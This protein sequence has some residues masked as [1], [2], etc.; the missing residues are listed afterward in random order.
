MPMLGASDSSTAIQDAMAKLREASAGGG[1]A[2]QA[3]A[4][5]PYRIPVKTGASYNLPSNRGKFD[6][7]IHTVGK[8][9]KEKHDVTEYFTLSDEGVSAAIGAWY[10]FDDDERSALMKRMWYLGLI[11]D[12]SDFDAAYKTWQA[13]VGHAARF[14]QTGKEIDPRD[15]L[16]I[17]GDAKSGAATKQK[18][19]P[20]TRRQIDLTNPETARAWITQAF[21]QSMGRAPEEAEIRA[22]VDALNERE[23]ANPTVQTTTPTK[24]D[25]QGNAIDSVTSTSGGVDPQAYLQNQISND[26]E[27]T[28]HQAAGEL[29]PALL[30]A[31]GG[32]LS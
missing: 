12:P 15:V 25:D 28:A 19:G 4:V 11:K 21:A 17:L 18:A 26:P 24:W 2:A 3:A 27:A 7:D 13:A 6:D 1:G 29:Y 20:V 14:A 31:L 16:D 22:M 30:A 23:R 5:S 10:T 9:V 8:T 32:G